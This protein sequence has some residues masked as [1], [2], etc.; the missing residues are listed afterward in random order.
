MRTLPPLTLDA[1]SRLSG[2]ALDSVWFEYVLGWVPTKVGPDY[3][4]ENECFILTAGGELPRD[5]SLPRIGQIGYSYLCP[6]FGGFDSIFGMILE[7]G[8][9]KLWFRV[10]EE[11]RIK[12]RLWATRNSDVL[13]RWLIA[14]KL[15]LEMG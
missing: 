5:I 12:G 1:L 3:N 4:G 10:R 6:K 9:D 11:I 2:R 13:Y 7:H 8:S 14:D 15:G